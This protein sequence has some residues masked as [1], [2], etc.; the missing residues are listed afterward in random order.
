MK[1][2]T[3]LGLLF[4]TTVLNAQT[5]DIFVDA[6]RPDD[7][8]DGTTWATAKKTIQ[9]GIEAAPGFDNV[10]VKAG[11]YNLT[12]T[13]NLKNAA[14]KKIHLYGG[15]VGT[16]TDISE[17]ALSDKD[18][19]GITEPWEFTNETVINSTKIGEVMEGVHR[20]VD[21]LTI[22]HTVTTGSANTASIYTSDA[23]AI[24]RNCT[25][26]NSNIT[27]T[28]VSSN[29]EASIIEISGPSFKNN[30]IENNTVTITLTSGNPK[31]FPIMNVTGRS[32][33]ADIIVEG[34]IFRNNQSI[35]N[36][37]TG[38]D[39]TS[40][41]GAIINTTGTA[42]SNKILLINNIIHNNETTQTGTACN[43]SG[44]YSN[45][46][47][48]SNLTEV[49]LLNNTF[50]NNKAAN[51]I[52]YAFHGSQSTFQIK[53][54]ALWNNTAASTSRALR[55]SGAQNSGTNI[56]YNVSDAALHG[57]TPSG[58]GVTYTNNLEDLLSSNSG[59]NAPLF[60]TPTSTIGYENNGTV[61]TSRWDLST[62][63]SYLNEKGVA[64]AGLTEDKSGDLYD[65]PP[66]AG[67]Y[68]ISGTSSVDN[69]N[70][71]VDNVLVITSNG[72]TA[73]KD[74]TVRIISISG[75]LLETLTMKSGD[76]KEINT[77]GIYIIQVSTPSGTVSKKALF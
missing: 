72:F 4:L 14:S 70:L 35:V 45:L 7:S 67:A 57:T 52:L 59:S 74:C 9:A 42:E 26:S 51:A 29:I 32:D 34:N 20:V 23:S 16:E 10:F 75:Q 41:R 28:A 6:A 77:T 54:N 58:T 53:N 69:I 56:S 19:N 21:G 55:S 43:R 3:L 40:F 30:L 39:V 13:L 62:A 71:S 5:G 49:S 24:I 76:F 27:L 36:N 48:S 33:L 68:E 64:V 25:F 50:A 8:G 47:F 38:A 12:E 60:V 46:A 2:I 63:D 1:K 44:I 37:N 61:E 65:N 73:G 31:F 15:F 17:R 22:T 18:G 66:S 11:T